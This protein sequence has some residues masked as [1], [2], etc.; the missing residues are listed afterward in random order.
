[1]TD[2]NDEPGG[3]PVIERRMRILARRCGCAFVVDLQPGAALT[4]WV[5][6]SQLAP[7][8][9]E[10]QRQTDYRTCCT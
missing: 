6:N 9:N 8:A 2:A 10:I 1:V 5:P 3:S 4:A 7:T